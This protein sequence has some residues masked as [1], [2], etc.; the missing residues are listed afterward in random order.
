MAAG[1]IPFVRLIG[2][3][4]KLTPLQVTVDIVVMVGTGFTV[5][6]TVKVDPVPQLAVV[7]VT[8]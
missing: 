5:I 6:V 1:T 2:V 4:A 7:G 8:I 3:T